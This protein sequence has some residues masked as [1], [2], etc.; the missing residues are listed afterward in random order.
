MSLLDSNDYAN[1]M[2]CSPIPTASG[3]LQRIGIT[4][5]KL[6]RLNYYGGGSFLI[7][8]TKLKVSRI[9][10]TQTRPCSCGTFRHLITDK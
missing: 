4:F 2:S 7:I 6:F 5:Q 9:E 3:L 10:D 1:T 8:L